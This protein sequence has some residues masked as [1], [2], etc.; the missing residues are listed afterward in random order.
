MK[1]E[2]DFSSIYKEQV[3][4]LSA[5]IEQSGKGAE[6]KAETS[7]EDVASKLRTYF[8][9][10]VKSLGNYAKKI[11]N[12]EIN[13]FYDD[14]CNK[15]RK[16]GNI[17][18]AMT[19][20]SKKIRSKFDPLSGIK[21]DSTNILKR[22]DEYYKSSQKQVDEVRA[23]ISAGA[24]GVSLKNATANTTIDE[25]TSKKV[26]QQIGIAKKKNPDTD[27]TYINDIMHRQSAEIARMK[28]LE[29][30]FQKNADGSFNLDATKGFSKSDATA[31]E[32]IENLD[33]QVSSLVEYKALSEDVK[34]NWV[35]ISKLTNTA[36]S[37]R[38][39]NHNGIAT[40][41][42]D[43]A[44]ENISGK[45]NL[46]M[47]PLTD[48]SDAVFKKLQ[49]KGISSIEELT[50][51]EEAEMTSSIKARLQKEAEYD[52]I[53][54]DRSSPSSTVQ[55][56]NAKI[57]K[58]I[59]QGFNYA[60][61]DTVVNQL[62]TYK[63]GK[64]SYLSSD[65][66]P[67]AIDGTRAIG[68]LALMEKLKLEPDNKKNQDLMAGM[69]D[70]YKQ[71][72]AMGSVG[73]EGSSG[74]MVTISVKDL[75]KYIAEYIA[76]V[77]KKGAKE[78]SAKPVD[79]T[80]ST[81]PSPPDTTETKDESAE[82]KPKPKPKKP[83]KKPKTDKAQSEAEK[84]QDE[85]DAAK[86]AA[87]K[88][89]KEKAD[90][91]KAEADKEKEESNN[92]KKTADENKSKPKPK[93]KPKKPKKKKDT[94]EKPQEEAD[95]AKEAADKAAK[96]K[97]DKEKETA[98]SDKKTADENKQET[99]PKSKPK[100]PKKKPKS[101]EKSVDEVDKAE[102]EATAEEQKALEAQKKAEAARKAAAKKAQEEANKQRQQ[103]DN[104]KSKSTGVPASSIVNNTTVGNE[105]FDMNSLTGDDITD[106]ALLNQGVMDASKRLQTNYIKKA[107]LNS[108]ATEIKN[109]GKS[110]PSKYS[111]EIKILTDTINKDEAL[112][113]Q[114][115][116]YM[117]AQQMDT[118]IPA[119]YA[120]QIGVPTAK[121]TAENIVTPAIKSG[122]V[123]TI[124]SDTS[125]RLQTTLKEFHK[126]KAAQ[127]MGTIKPEELQKL[128]GLKVQANEQGQILSQFTK[129][130]RL[131]N[132]DYNYLHSDYMKAYS[133]EA[134]VKTLDTKANNPRYGS[135][136]VQ[137]TISATSKKLQDLLIAIHKL[138]ANKEVGIIKPEDE[139]KL[140]GLTIQATEA[141]NLL[142]NFSK[143]ELSSNKEYNYL[144]GDYMKNYST[145]SYLETL[146]K[147]GMVSDE[148]RS[149][150]EREELR[151]EK[152]GVDLG[153]I[154]LGKFNNE[155]KSYD[156]N[157][158]KNDYLSAL[159]KSDEL[160]ASLARERRN[161]AISFLRM[162]D[163]GYL[164]TKTLM[165]LNPDTLSPNTR[166][167]FN[168]ST[169]ERQNVEA[170][171][172]ASEEKLKSDPALAGQYAN[173]KQRDEKYAMMQKSFTNEK[174]ITAID[175]AYMNLINHEKEYQSLLMKRH[176]NG[177][178]LSSDE[179]LALTNL[180]K[181]RDK[182]LGILNTGKDTRNVRAGYQQMFGNVSSLA[183][184][185]L[186][187]SFGGAGIS[188]AYS[189]VDN[190]SVGKI[191]DYASALNKL[192]A[193]LVEYSELVRTA[194]K[195][196]LTKGQVQR[197]K[198]LENE[199]KTAGT[200][201]SKENWNTG[202]GTIIGTAGSI[203]GA[204]KAF[205]SWYGR[206][207]TGQKTIAEGT[208]KK[209]SALNDKGV[210]SIQV[211][212][213]DGKLSTLAVKYDKVTG[214]IKLFNTTLSSGK[215][216]VAQAKSQYDSLQKKIAELENQ[217]EG[218]TDKFKTD[219]AEA[220]DK[221]AEVGGFINAAKGSDTL[222]GNKAK[223]DEILAQTKAQITQLRSNKYQLNGENQI[224]MHGMS[225][226]DTKAALESTMSQMGRVKDAGTWT[227]MKDGTFQLNRQIVT[228]DGSLK[229]V[230]ATI[231]DVHGRG[232][233]AV[234]SAKKNVSG[235][236][237]WFAKLGQEWQKLARYMISFASVYQVFDF[238]RNG[239]TE[240]KQLDE[241]FA[242]ISYTMNTSTKSLNDMK[243]SSIELAKAMKTDVSTVVDADKIYSNMSE[244]T[245]DIVE[246][247]KPT[248][249]LSNVSGLSASDSA[250]YIQAITQQF[251]LDDDAKTAEHISDVLENISSK[252]KMDFQTGIKD[253][254]E[255]VKV[256]GSVAYDSGLSFEQFGA[257]IAKTAESTR[258]SGKE[259]PRRT[260]MCEQ[261]RI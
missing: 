54:Y 149:A 105:Y 236:Q 220:K 166:A 109:S 17:E 80:S 176:A 24:G 145:E 45:A 243:T 98:D 16:T 131:S 259:L 41:K 222:G 107:R 210:G 110:V 32:N 9:S 215:T 50:K 46:A 11:S 40:E 193:K 138:K 23:R 79:N 140:K 100:K 240:V 151:I 64:G 163:R 226:D 15:A 237:D 255:G 217:T 196:D 155:G 43:S 112:V 133:T 147:K 120:S 108:E 233:V 162:G 257:I 91:E 161:Q 229:K 58:A 261:K 125:K 160:D 19:D 116:D 154:K 258:L 28:E 114:L 83:K 39:F 14:F 134:Y 144:N 250:N 21:N 169:L 128:N 22:F 209:Y 180:N 183:Q 62:Y 118:Q 13:K 242:S 106:A 63:N 29:S 194:Q 48:E 139:Q 213:M 88:A 103:A 168:Q 207:S 77:Y 65:K 206:E 12:D 4:K 44:L 47:K 31:K 75:Q 189:L 186:A 221:L 132:A 6:K 223:A 195:Q 253:I 235:L 214:A 157:N 146:K 90:A 101:T 1:E 197:L 234:V 218:R 175:K 156:I 96:E 254:A 35:E 173:L 7:M 248:I 56:D 244:T 8:S 153:F 117:N 122:S 92:D 224:D 208:V 238:I 37:S 192:E 66:T 232:D 143:E 25:A 49:E 74:K 198:Q 85:A 126:L 2:F 137:S 104:S 245:N 179:Q 199:I 142:A 67:K 227:Q 127:Q 69:D 241:S 171:L 93:S 61:E 200:V 182:N 113:G 73:F 102:E 121:Y 204:Q 59:A 20:V 70:A 135:G 55:Q 174:D 190:G 203:G 78:E 87:D 111:S 89:A 68:T 251:N 165:D 34:R 51:K 230:R 247:A 185:E 53:N 167:A 231:D 252:V 228:M 115:L 260:E 27:S 124:I 212:G 10:N 84:A 18:K 158:N 187:D 94:S 184:K 57:N 71:I 201:L 150:K 42:V 202:N 148:K 152:A 52:R 123:Q 191:E 3:E 76:K 216:E 33:K 129:Q 172:R 170:Y 95:A 136:N 177:S 97:A 246:K 30:Q 178:I 36:G 188:K 181:N 119:Y 130:E 164:K 219:L 82:S 225:I 60:R 26:Q 211:E 86:E 239:I 81:P 159:L 141:Y 256:A 38:Q 205:E 5:A 72:L 99:K 249:M